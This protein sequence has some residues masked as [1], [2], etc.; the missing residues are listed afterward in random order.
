MQ[1]ALAGKSDTLVVPCRR[2]GAAVVLAEYERLFA[3]LASKV[4]VKR[5]YPPVGRAEVK[6]CPACEGK[7]GKGAW[8]ESPC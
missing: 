4:N 1:M 7:R 3:R 5:G 6:L 8:G 2:C